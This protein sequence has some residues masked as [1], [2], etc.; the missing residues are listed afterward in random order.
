VNGIGGSGDFTRNGHLS[1]IAL[2]STAA[3]GEISRIVPMATHVDH[4]EHD[5]DVV[6]TERGVAD[7][8]GKSPDE[9][10]DL[11]VEQ[12]AHP[13]FRPALRAYVDRAR[14]RGG[15][16]PHEFSSAFEWHT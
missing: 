13:D 15:H 9:R 16:E 1:V 3:G 6:V 14:E 4:A 8:R 10:A 5:V 7:L 11:L 2:G 12:C